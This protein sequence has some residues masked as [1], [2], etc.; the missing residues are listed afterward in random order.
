MCSLHGAASEHTNSIP[1][2]GNQVM[3]CTEENRFCVFQF[4]MDTESAGPKVRA[5]VKQNLTETKPRVKLTLWKPGLSHL[6]FY[7][8]AV[9][10]RETWHYEYLNLLQESPS[11]SSEE[12][13]VSQ[14]RQL[15]QI[16]ETCWSKS[17]SNHCQG[18]LTT[19]GFTAIDGKVVFRYKTWQKKSSQNRW[20]Y[21]IT[22]MNK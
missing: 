1:F 17:M 19:S 7:S 10:Y 20:I 9:L 18:P 11:F 13:W 2:K 12:K 14:L 4:L 21:T 5:G 16:Q 22:L 15:T 6:L 3:G 8:T